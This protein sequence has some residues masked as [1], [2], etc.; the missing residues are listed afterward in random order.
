MTD[1]TTI[2]VPKALRDAVMRSARAEGLT[3]AEF[4][5]L[6]TQEHA[7]SQRFEEVRQAYV[8]A[9]TDPDYVGI[10]EAWD[11][12]VHDGLGDA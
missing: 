1:M 4:L 6:V 8:A 12:T 3:A 11:V 2:K 10:T 5:R 9:P 7:R